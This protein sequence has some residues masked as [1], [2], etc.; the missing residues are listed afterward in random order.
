MGKP[1]T[2]YRVIVRKNANDLGYKH[3]DIV[4]SFGDLDMWLAMHESL[5]VSLQKHRARADAG[6][7]DKPGVDGFV[8][9]WYGFRGEITGAYV[10]VAA[11]L[12]TLTGKH[13]RGLRGIMKCLRAM[14]AVKVVPIRDENGY[15]AYYV[16]AKHKKHASLWHEAYKAGLEI[17]KAA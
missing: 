4:V 6:D 14:R 1:R 15:V 2:Y 17:K 12:L 16:P 3:L 10:D 8:R 7:Y 11:R 5:T 13:G 9:R